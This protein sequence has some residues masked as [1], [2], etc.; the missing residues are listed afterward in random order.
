MDK[1]VFVTKNEALADLRANYHNLGYP[2]AFSGI[3]KIQ[4]YYN[5]L[6]STS[7][8]ENFLASSYAYTVHREPKKPKFNP[9]FVYS[10]R[11][12]LQLDLC[13]IRKISKYNNNFNYIFVAIDIFSRRLFCKLIHKKTAEQTLNAFKSVLLE[14]GSN[15]SVK[16]VHCDK[17]SELKNRLFLQFCKD[18]NITVIFPETSHHVSNYKIILTLSQYISLIFILAFQAPFVERANRSLQSI[19]FKYITSTQNF[20]FFDKMEEI[21]YTYNNRPHRGLNN[22]TPME[23]EKKENHVKVK[24]IN[25]KRYSSIKKTKRQKYKVNDLVRI[26]KLPNRFLRSYQPQN[27]D[28]IFKVV[29]IKKSLPKFLYKLQS[30]SNEDIIGYFY[31]EELV[32]V[33]KSNEIYLVDKILKSKGNKR[34]VRWK[35]YGKEHDSWVNA[36][37]IGPV[38]GNSWNQL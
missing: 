19:I 10:L 23:A 18:K 29:S 25:E 14:C 1:P 5:N 7:D 32:K 26:S 8:I 21:V 34:L 30:L 17:G 2:I 3:S 24:Q 22:M 38:K 15:P 37:D 9:T 20:K 6:L 35:G 27:Q 31:T 13:D 11:E 28:E 16:T 4:K 33:D 12:Q 36:R